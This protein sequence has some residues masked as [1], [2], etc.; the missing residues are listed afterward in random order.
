M[1]SALIYL[2]PVKDLAGTL[3]E[4]VALVPVSGPSNVGFSVSGVT[5]ELLLLIS[6]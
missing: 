2:L 6:N 3:V 5:T 4:S 1:I